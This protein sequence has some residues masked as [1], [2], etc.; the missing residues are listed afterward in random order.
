MGSASTSDSLLTGRLSDITQAP[1]GTVTIPPRLWNL[2]TEVTASQLTG[3]HDA[4]ATLFL[5]QGLLDDIHNN[6]TLTVEDIM[7]CLQQWS[8]HTEPTRAL[9]AALSNLQALAQSR[10]ARTANVSSQMMTHLEPTGLV[11]SLLSPTS[12]VLPVTLPLTRSFS[13]TRFVLAAL[14]GDLAWVMHR[15]L[16]THFHQQGLLNDFRLHDMWDLG[17]AAG[18]Y[19]DLPTTWATFCTNLLQG[20][21]GNMTTARLETVEGQIL[22][23]YVWRPPSGLPAVAR[24]AEFDERIRSLRHTSGTPIYSL[25]SSRPVQ[26]IM[27]V[28]LAAHQLCRVELPQE[29]ADLPPTAISGLV[30]CINRLEAPSLMCRVWP[31]PSPSRIL[32]VASARQVPRNVVETVLCDIGAPRAL[33]VHWAATMEEEETW[34]QE[35]RLLLE[36]GRLGVTAPAITPQ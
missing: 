3:I 4:I 8:I 18:I 29:W 23:W 5:R 11:G 32:I 1:D 35:A 16:V 34:G 12:A 6:L 14:D 17:S 9:E 26:P 7:A 19:C 30:T 2:I 33:Q 22:N 31:M 15:R 21:Q 24:L 20:H 27:Q 13:A 10:R 25:L 28:S 36:G